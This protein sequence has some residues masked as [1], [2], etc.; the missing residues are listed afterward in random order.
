MSASHVVVE[1]GGWEHE[2]CG[3]AVEIGDVVEYW[4]VSADGAR[5]FGEV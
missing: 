1:I 5:R 4:V 3:L 2:C